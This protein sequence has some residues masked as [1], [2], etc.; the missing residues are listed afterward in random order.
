MDTLTLPTI[1]NKSFSVKNFAVEEKINAKI[2][3]CA[4]VKEGPKMELL[5]TPA[6]T[7]AYLKP[8]FE[9]CSSKKINEF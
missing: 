8:P 9:I 7:G 5:G 2:S 1:E 6:H 3:L 4:R